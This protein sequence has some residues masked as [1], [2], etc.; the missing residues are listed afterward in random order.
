[1]ATNSLITTWLQA[2]AATN[3]VSERRKKRIG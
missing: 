3:K 1:L 2:L